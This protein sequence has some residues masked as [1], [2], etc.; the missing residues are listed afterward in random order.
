MLHVIGIYL[1]RKNIS[2]YLFRQFKHKKI[3]LF[4]N[5]RNLI[6]QFYRATVTF[7]QKEFQGFQGST[8]LGADERRDSIC[9]P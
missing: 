8:F 5:E 3:V 9:M 2:E 1:L 6:P 7:I 4:A